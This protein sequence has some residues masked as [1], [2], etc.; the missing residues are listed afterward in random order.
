[1]TEKGLSV[2]DKYNLKIYST[3]KGRG[4]I[5]CNTDKGLKLLREYQGNGKHLLF[6]ASVLEQLKAGGNIPVDAYVLNSDNT[7]ISTDE[8]DT[9]Y[10]LRDWYEGREF[11]VKNYSDIIKAVRTLAILHNDLDRVRIEEPVEDC[12][13]TDIKDEFSRHNRELKKV[14]NYLSDKHRKT[15][16]EL[17]AYAAC[18]N[19][20]KEGISAI[21]KINH[22]KFDD[23]KADFISSRSLCHGDYN[24]HNV[25]VSSGVCSVINFNKMNYNVKIYDLYC[26]M[27]KIL[28]KYD[29]DIKLAYKMITEYDEIRHIDNNSMQVLVV[30]FQYPE[31]FWKIMNYYY[32]SNKAWIP[33]KNLEKLN[34][35]IDQNEKRKDFIATLI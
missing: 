21:D 1:M 7:Y 31:K 14:R 20:Y 17:I 9:K 30:L 13:I 23:I 11:D 29:W 18:D 19:F 25:I 15:N 4:A 8:D 28:E 22:I 33:S 26:F 24:H 2:L 10:V 32:N 5:I 34:R 35:V 27:R 12:Y 6:E 16:F 3:T